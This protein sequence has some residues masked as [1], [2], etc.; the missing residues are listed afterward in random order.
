MIFESRKFRVVEKDIEFASG[1]QE[2]WETVEQK[3]N[4]GARVL[5]L[6]NRQELIFIREYRG[7]AEKYVLR[8]PTGVIEA[9]EDSKDAA[10]RELKEETGFAPHNLEFL[11]KLESTS[12]YYKATSL[13][14]FYADSAEETGSTAREIGEQAMEVIFIP[15]EK[16]LRMVENVEFED[17]Q[18]VYALLLLKK[19]LR[20]KK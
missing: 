7:A 18:T 1:D 9:G 17:I 6:N 2:T 19:H 15:L 10:R 13:H 14:L 3:G 5:A 11:G 20:E 16:A 4:G 12:G 8:I